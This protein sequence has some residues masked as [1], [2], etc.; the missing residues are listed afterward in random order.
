MHHREQEHDKETKDEKKPRSTLFSAVK[1]RDKD[2][3]KLKGK[4]R[5]SDQLERL[6]KMIGMCLH[7][8]QIPS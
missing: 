1:D 8:P 5:E 2:K 3:S 7:H 6:T 4:E